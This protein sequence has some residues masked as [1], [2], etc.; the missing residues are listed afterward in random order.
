VGVYFGYSKQSTADG[1]PVHCFCGVDFNDIAAKVDDRRIRRMTCGSAAPALCQAA[2]RGPNVL[3]RQGAGISTSFKLA[4][5]PRE[6]V[7]RTLQID[8]GPQ[9]VW[10]TWDQDEKPLP[11][12]RRADLNFFGKTLIANSPAPPEFQPHFLP[13]GGWYLPVPS[14][15]VVSIVYNRGVAGPVTR[16]GRKTIHGGEKESQTT[17]TTDAC[18]RVTREGSPRRSA[19]GGV[20]TIGLADPTSFSAPDFTVSGTARPNDST[21]FGTLTEKNTGAR[22]TSNPPSVPCTMDPVDAQIGNWTLSF[23]SIPLGF[24]VL[25]VNEARMREPMPSTSTS[26]P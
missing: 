23:Q 19:D 8:V 6:D 12:L 2:R 16:R 3:R 22:F 15:G 9:E 10:I 21:V 18:I 24:Y 5:G 14:F 7:W 4:G 26:Q 25:G 17:G 1:R 20:V 11:P 13:Q